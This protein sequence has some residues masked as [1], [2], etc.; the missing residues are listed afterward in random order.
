MRKFLAISILAVLF[1]N[2]FGFYI[3]FMVN[4]REVKEE[5]MERAEKEGPE[6]LR[7]FSLS[8]EEYSQLKWTQK[9]REFSYNGRVFDV[10]RIEFSGQFVKLYVEDDVVENQLI[11]DFVSQVHK[12]QQNEHTNSPI[13]SLLNSLFSEFT[14]SSSVYSHYPSKF[15]L[16]PNS[17]KDTLYHSFISDSHSPPPDSA[18]S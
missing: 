16:T 11:D 13:K 7:L 12:K 18:L 8:R 9:G 6:H 3:A 10:S 5:M 4:Q 14:I 15:T 2:I 17:H 1:L